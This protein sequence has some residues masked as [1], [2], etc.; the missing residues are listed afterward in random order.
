VHV[1][2][3]T[4]TLPDQRIFLHNVSWDTYMRLM[5]DQASSSTPRFTYDNGALEI[6]MPLAIHERIILATQVLI[7]AVALEFEVDIEPLG[8]TTFSREDLFR[9]FEPDGCF[10]VQHAAAVRGKD[11]INLALDPPPDIVMEIEIT[12][13]SLPK[14]PIFERFG[15]PEVWQY[16]GSNVTFLILDPEQPVGARPF[17][18]GYTSVERSLALP[19]ITA[20]ALTQVLSG[21]R[22]QTRAQWLR[23]APSWAKALRRV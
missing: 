1:T 15:V 19:M 2:T 12:R 7:D 9:G 20:A 11:R 3:I 5:E 23:Q 8:S 18:A 4:D 13:G 14:L 22:R 21:F 10:Y 17:E 6:T 16:D